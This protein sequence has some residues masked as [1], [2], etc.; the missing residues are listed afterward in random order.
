MREGERC[1]YYF[2]DDMVH[3]FGCFNYAGR[4]LTGDSIFSRCFPLYEVYSWT[5][6]SEEYMTR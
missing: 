2:F 3:E 4:D 6:R 5:Y 1:G